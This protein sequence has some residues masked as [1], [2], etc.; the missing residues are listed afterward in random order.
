MSAVEIRDGILHV[1]VSSS[2]NGTSLDRD[3]KIAGAEV[4]NSSAATDGS[5]RAILLYGA[6]AN[7]CAGGNVRAF[8]AADDRPEFLL[9]LAN[10]FHAFIKALSRVDIPVIAAVHGWAAGAGM[11]IV[12]HADIAIGGTSTQFRPAYAGIGLSPDGGLTWS[13]PRVVGAA[14]ARDII[15]G[16]RVLDATEAERIGLLSRIVADDEVYDTALAAAQELANGPAAAYAATRRLLNAS[17]SSTLSDQLDAEAQSISQLSGTPT[18]IEG[19]D[20]FVSKRKPN[21][22]N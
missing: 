3:A 13:L 1:A 11:S 15:L 10:D 14:R 17:E 8:A 19:V 16:N 12:T 2:A 21:W 20:A 6:G 5:I 4:L 22:P 18:G 7:F 9:G